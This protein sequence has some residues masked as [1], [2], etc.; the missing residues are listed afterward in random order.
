MK[1]DHHRINLKKEIRKIGVEN[2]FRVY[3]ANNILHELLRIRGR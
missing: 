3:I 2:F 1:S